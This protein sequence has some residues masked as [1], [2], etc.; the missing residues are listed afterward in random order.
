MKKC[1]ILFLILFLSLSFAEANC[2]SS[3]NDKTKV[4][5]IGT[6]HFNNPGLDS[7]N[8]EVDDVFTDQRQKEID[9]LNNKLSAFNPSKIFLEHAPQYQM[10]LDSLYDLFYSDQLDLISY[11]KGRDERFQIGFKLAKKL[12]LK[13]LYAVD[14]YAPWLG[15][16]VI[17]MAKENYATLYDG[18]N[19][20]MLERIETQ[21]D[22]FSKQTICEN[23]YFFNLPEQ[24]MDNHKM[25]TDFF[26]EIR[27]DTILPEHKRSYYN[28]EDELYYVCIEEQFAGAEL[29]AEWYKRNFK[30]FSN[31]ISSLD[32]SE[33]RIMILFGQGHI[34][35]LKHLFEDHSDFEL[36][37]PLIYLE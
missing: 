31:I 6:Y 37:D 9:E 33:E 20:T 2:Q 3:K 25:Y 8:Q 21:E 29:V 13:K 23:L 16:A 10:Q 4:L 5:L 1:Q 35:I 22:L 19:D 30:I 27:S 14:A 28:E 15:D 34:R 36:V 32:R 17:N 11:E 24:I 18:F 7:Y 12:K 26:M